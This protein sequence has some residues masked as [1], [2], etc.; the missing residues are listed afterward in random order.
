MSTSSASSLQA[1]SSNSPITSAALLQ[2]HASAPNP[3]AAALEQAVTDRN[4]LAGQNSS[5]WKLVEKQ[6]AGYSQ[7][8]RELERV[9]GERDTWRARAGGKRDDQHQGHSSNNPDNNEPK[10]STPRKSPDEQAPRSTSSA[11]LHS[12]SHSSLLH[13]ERQRA[14]SASSQHS[15]PYTNPSSSLS[16]SRSVHSSTSAEPNGTNNN[17]G[18]TSANL[19]FPSLG[20]SPIHTRTA[21]SH[22][23]P[24]QNVHHQHTHSSQ[25]S[26]SPPINSLPQSQRSVPAPSPLGISQP[27]RSESLPAS[28]QAGPPIR[29]PNNT[30]PPPRK[31][32]LSEFNGSPNLNGNASQP[33][34][35]NPTPLPHTLAQPQL[36]S[37]DPGLASPNPPFMHSRADRDSQGSHDSRITL[38]EEAR[39]YIV[40]MTDSPLASPH[41]A[42]FVT[43]PS[44]LSGSSPNSFDDVNEATTIVL[45]DRVPPIG[46]GH[47]LMKIANPDPEGNG[48]DSAASRRNGHTDNRDGLGYMGPPPVVT[49][50][51]ASAGPMSPPRQTPLGPSRPHD[52]NGTRLTPRKPP[53]TEATRDELGSMF[54]DMD[55][56]SGLED[57]SGIE[58]EPLDGT[59]DGFDSPIQRND[60]VAGSDDGYSTAKALESSNDAYNKERSR[61]VKPRA[62]VE[63]FPL[64]PSSDT[65]L[66]HPSSS[67]QLSADPGSSTSVFSNGIPSGD[68]SAYSINPNAANLHSASASTSTLL[69]AS[70]S[71]PPSALA[72]SS[73]L[74][75]IPSDSSFVLPKGTTT[76]TLSSLDK[77]NKFRALPLLISDLPYTAISV[78]S[79][80]VRPNERGKEVLS[81]TV[82]VSIDR[83][84]GRKSNAGEHM[85]EKSK[86]KDSWTIEK[87]YS[88]VLALD[89]RVRSTV[90]KGAARKMAN[91]PEGRLWKDHAPAKVDQR[92]AVLENYLQ[93]LVNLPVKNNDEVIAFLT[94]DIVRDAK[95]PVLQAGHKEGYLTKRGKNFGGW[96]TRFFVLQGPVLEYYDCRGGTHL[97]SI[98]VAGAQIGRQ[99]RSENRGS[100]ADEEKEYRHA[101][102][103]VEARKN[104]AGNHP[105]HVLCAESD[106]D[107]DSW[108]EML[109]R[110]FSGVY[111]EEPVTYSARGPSPISTNTQDLDRTPNGYGQ[112]PARSSHSIDIP[113]PYTPTPREHAQRR[114]MSR[115]DITISK[116]PAIPISQLAPDASN[117]KLFQSTPMLGETTTSPVKTHPS[118]VERHGEREK[119]GGLPSSLP[120]PSPL[121]SST[122]GHDIGSSSSPLRSNSEMGHYPDLQDSG[123]HRQPSPEKHRDRAREVDS[124]KSYMPSS[125][126]SLV[127]PVTERVPS[128]DKMDRAKI[129]GPINGT[130]IPAG[131]K[132]GGKDAE[133]TPITPSDRREKA[134][135]RSFWN[136][137]RPNDKLQPLPTFI[138][139]AVFGVPLEESLDVAQ[140]A[141]LPA[142]VFRAIQYLEAKRADQE[143]G[144]YR[145]SGSSAVIKSLKDRFN[146]E[147]DI[148]L[149]ASDEY[150]DPHAIAGLL[151]SFLRELPASILTR[152]LHLKFLAVIDFVD[153]QERIKELSQLIAALPIANYSLLR[154]LTAHLILIVQNSGVNKMTM[155]N[156]GIVFSPTLGIPAGVFS[157]MLGEFNRVFNVDPDYTDD[158]SDEKAAAAGA[159]GDQLTVGDRPNGTDMA[160]RN[161]Q[162]YSDAAAD[163]L[164]GLAGRKLTVASDDGQSDGDDFSVQDE[165][166][167]ET[168]E[169]DVT[170]ESSSS[171]L[172]TGD[173]ARSQHFIDPP[174]T[175][176]AS[177]T[178]KASSVAATRGLNVSITPSDRGHRYSRMMGLP[179]SPRPP[180]SPR[181]DASSSDK[182]SP[183]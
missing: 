87:M 8:L 177:K 6:R 154:A 30:V 70:S 162:R 170:V 98:Q 149:L 10:H 96:K 159:E 168:A 74:A 150:W 48:P 120:D 73:N 126:T 75:S 128:P 37:P 3:L 181:T 12:Q 44:A 25:R 43:K 152:D 97:G 88:D 133:A 33:V 32:S 171:N 153:A 104:A 173:S 62:A 76:L 2:Q 158:G 69:S 5:L 142:I 99:Q 71:S 145:L 105:R 132:F 179:S 17:A 40:N 121:S 77:G 68:S 183:Q 21:S 160:R 56:S 54:L 41:V 78:S 165:S 80:F 134:K 130:P 29:P 60:H 115:D 178:S 139:R 135:S 82:L 141:S 16:N 123:K 163:K 27:L 112:P 90:G 136:F 140:I 125:S 107:R 110:Y 85:N 101:F 166:G 72:S 66:A 9:R 42:Q 7:I 174:E 176:I 79:S 102:L 46:S 109:V 59:E 13:S 15:L 146:A 113:P 148:D 137:G 164:L 58:D 169:G 93:T 61:K 51:P 81:F 155:R 23:H 24:P 20:S 36:L 161:S 118:P 151:K 122:A 83:E 53:S 131:Y 111:T 52:I 65:S 180:I 34:V 114:G 144:I 103:I 129:S 92:K 119:A 108:V 35:N 1:S 86:P 95:K 147:G 19:S 89:Q 47:G 22:P 182:A 18:P 84:G 138:P 175:P 38:P 116:G 143:E 67:L 167:P 124:R 49:V 26:H 45:D 64:P 117:A 156:V 91:L 94:S 50:V 31:M 14:G 157:L 106:E 11:S 172:S 100:T 28:L 4:A 55:E 63:D 127:P 39:A 57:G